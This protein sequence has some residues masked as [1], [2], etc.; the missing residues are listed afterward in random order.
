M[1]T[2]PCDPRAES[3]A[4]TTYGPIPSAA[5]TVAGSM[6]GSVGD[7]VAT[8]LGIGLC[9]GT[10]VAGE[11]VWAR[12]GVGS[13]LAS[14]TAGTAV[15]EAVR[16]SPMLPAAWLQAAIVIAKATMLKS[17]IELFIAGAPV[18]VGIGVRDWSRPVAS[19]SPPRNDQVTSPKAT[20]VALMHDLVAWP[21]PLTNYKTP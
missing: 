14:A 15:G 6:A 7:G 18:R 9:D 5:S 4:P 13:G 10:V 3:R 11:A 1:E 12:L 16:T 17:R 19:G 20:V 21:W 8:G 2:R